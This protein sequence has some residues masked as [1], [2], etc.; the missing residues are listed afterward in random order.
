MTIQVTFDSGQKQYVVS[1]NGKQIA[2]LPL[3]YLAGR[4]ASHIA[5]DEIEKAFADVF[6]NEAKLKTEYQ[7]RDA[8]LIMLGLIT[9]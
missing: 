1:N 4:K 9:A 6:E 5:H 3:V 8:A 2:V 7:R